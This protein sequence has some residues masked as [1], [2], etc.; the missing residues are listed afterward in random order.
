[1]NVCGSKG[2]TNNIAQ[3]VACVGKNIKKNIKKY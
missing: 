2:S 3:M 1:M